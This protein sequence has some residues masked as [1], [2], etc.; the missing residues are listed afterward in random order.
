M[1]E[2]SKL[3][4]GIVFAL[5]TSLLAVYFLLVLHQK[6]P[7]LTNTYIWATKQQR[8]Q[9]NKKAEY[10]LLSVI[11]GGLTIAALFETLYIFTALTL[12]F[13]LFWIAL[14]LVLAYAIYDAVKTTTKR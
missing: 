13:V 6:G 12:F 5:I 1:M 10:R 7:I 3:I 14:G 11:F 9:M 4:L 8:E 2:P